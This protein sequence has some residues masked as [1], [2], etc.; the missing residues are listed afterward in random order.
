M[1]SGK[2]ETTMPRKPVEPASARQPLT[3][4]LLQ[5]EAGA[6]NTAV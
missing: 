2:E 5:R 1:D 6:F 4:D 3:V